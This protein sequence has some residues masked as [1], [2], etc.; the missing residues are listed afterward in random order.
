MT[1]Y[2][3]VGLA[4]GGGGARG[5][6]HLGV[7]KVLESEGIAFDL[8]AGTS[9]G[10]IAGAMYAQYPNAD[11]VRR[12]V[13]DYLRS[14]SFRKTKLFFIKKHYEEEK[15]TSFIKNLK[16]YLQKGIFWG[17]SLRRSSFISEQD[18]I[19]HI[20]RLFE[21]KGI[22]ETVIPFFAVAAD[23]AYGNEVVLSEGPI[24]RAIAAS[25]A[26]PGIFPPITIGDSKL[27][28]GGWVNQVPV[29]PL[30][31]RGAD[32]VI[33][34][35]ASEAPAEMRE[36]ASGLDIVL[37]AGE[38]TRK[39]LSTAQLAKADLVIRPDVGKL[40]WSDFW[41]VEEVIQRGEEAARAQVEELKRQLWKK[42]MKKLLMIKA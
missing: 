14:E 6:A 7:L 34:V 36:L 31:H 27:I 15:R 40:H 41:R 37:R 17:I 16:S 4:L 39:I 33:A 13:C 3:K 25:C 18:Y 30:I 8:I 5:I 35:D 21:E 32:F 1:K 10:A 19:D 22:E 24:R 29:E 9:F 20:S 26:I 38:I 42:K 11:L 28:D 23:L 2:F 12:R